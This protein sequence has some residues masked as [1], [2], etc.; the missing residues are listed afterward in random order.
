METFSRAEDP[1]HLDLEYNHYEE[2]MAREA[3]TPAQ[4]ALQSLTRPPR[5]GS[6]TDVELDIESKGQHL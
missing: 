2:K 1:T 6:D 3:M 5:D 4:R